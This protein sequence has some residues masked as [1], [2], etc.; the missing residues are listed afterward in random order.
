MVYFGEGAALSDALVVLRGILADDVLLFHLH[1]EML[2]DEIDRAPDGKERIALAA[3]RAADLPDGGER[4]RRHLMREGEGLHRQRCGGR[5]DGHEHSRADAGA[6]RAP[7]AAG[8]AGNALSPL[9]HLTQRFFQLDL[10][11]GVPVCRQQCGADHNVVLR[12]VHMA[13]RLRHH[14]PDNLHGVFGIAFQAQADDRIQPC[15]VAFVTD[16]MA[17]HA[18][19]L[20]EKPLPADGA[21]HFFVGLQIDQRRFADQTFLFHRH[22]T[23]LR[24]IPS[25]QHPLSCSLIH[26]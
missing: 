3:A 22:V 16:K 10:S 21:A 20:R 6:A 12:P 8:A 11:S 23:S 2:G 4:F 1:A 25:V 13:E 26:P 24:I 15:H 14:G 17:V 18:A 5:D 9:H 7:E 19:R